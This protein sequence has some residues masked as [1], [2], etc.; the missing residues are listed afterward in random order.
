MTNDK[1]QDTCRMRNQALKGV[2]DPFTNYPHQS[3][4]KSNKI[5]KICAGMVNLRGETGEQLIPVA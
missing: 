4:T 1:C 5:Q 3:D 2:Q